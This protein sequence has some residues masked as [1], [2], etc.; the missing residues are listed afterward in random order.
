MARLRRQAPS[1]FSFQVSNL[2]S[3]ICHIHIAFQGNPGLLGFY[4][5]FL[6][7]IWKGSAPG[8]AI[9]AHS[10]IGHTPGIEP[11]TSRK[12]SASTVGLHAQI[13]TIIEVLDDIVVTFGTGTK[14]VLVGH[15]VGSWLTLQVLKARPNA[16]SGTFLLFPT[17]TNI[18]DTPNGRI[19]SVC[20][21]QLN[22]IVPVAM[23]RP[24]SIVAL[25][26]SSS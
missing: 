8:L 19:L 1:Y 9:L 16:V 4:V 14:V 11:V 18:A 17:I 20:L 10:H 21:F 24:P 22:V 23:T 12:R 7:A 6:S 5:P 15:S 25:P 2:K 26:P 3:I 13:Q